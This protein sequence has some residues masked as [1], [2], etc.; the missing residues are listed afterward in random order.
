MK[1]ADRGPAVG[2]RYRN[3]LSLTM[4]VVW[5]ANSFAVRTGAVDSCWPSDRSSSFVSRSVDLTSWGVTA[6]S[7]IRQHNRQPP[8]KQQ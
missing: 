7:A 2:A 8:R 1:H 4:D 6:P 5:C 3:S